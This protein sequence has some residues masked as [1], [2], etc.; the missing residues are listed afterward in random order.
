MRYSQVI[1][2][3]SA[4]ENGSIRAAARQTNLSQPALSQ[5][6][7]RLEDDLGVPLLDRS[8]R[9]VRLTSYG[10]VLQARAKLIRAE[11]E[12][13]HMDIAQMK[14][15]Q[16][17]HVA[18]GLITSISLLAAPR[19]IRAFKR[20]YPRVRVSINDQFYNNTLAAL[21]D[22][23]IDFAIGPGFA[24]DHPQI[25][26]EFLFETEFVALGR[27][28]HPKARARSLA[29]L[30][31]EQW[32]EPVDDHARD[33]GAMFHRAGLPEPVVIRCRSLSNWLPL[34]LENDAIMILPRVL[35]R[36]P[37]LAN[38]LQA[39]EVPESIKRAPYYMFT[40]ADSPLTPAAES[41]A[42]EFR[43]SVRALSKI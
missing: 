23:T 42:R 33:T 6:I 9:G 18:I 4:A 13:A 8:V 37:G 3:L 16:E 12:R 10:R 20:K 19:A 21:R 17:G 43:V 34:M 22:S 29:E 40:N 35:L 27:K 25:K 1:A 7:R 11:F 36:A 41:L 31:E 38:A 32:I 28:N 14:G 15:S 30:H 2:F 5:M 39:I 26:S 24:S